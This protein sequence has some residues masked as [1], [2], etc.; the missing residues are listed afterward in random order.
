MLCHFESLSFGFSSRGDLEG[1]DECTVSF[2]SMTSQG[3]L[4]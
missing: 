3:D 1:M 4:G 2:H